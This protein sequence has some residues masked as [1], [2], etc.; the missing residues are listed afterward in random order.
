[1]VYDITRKESFENIDRWLKELKDH[2]DSNIVIMLVGNKCDMQHLKAVSTDEG[3]LYAQKNNLSFI[4]TSALD[5]TNVE[6]AFRTILSEIYTLGSK[7][8]LEKG[9]AGSNFSPNAA[10]TIVINPPAEERKSEK[11]KCC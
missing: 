9:G 10:Q 5:S 2:A 6:S 4:E 8:A 7:K 1:M 3:S 11:S